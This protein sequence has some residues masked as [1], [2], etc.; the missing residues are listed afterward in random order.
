MG[1]VDLRRARVAGYSEFAPALGHVYTRR[2]K[3]SGGMEPGKKAP[4]QESEPALISVFFFISASS[5]QSEIPLV[6][7]RERKLSIYYV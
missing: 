3:Q 7:K 6:E 2:A 5:E 1:A 4:V